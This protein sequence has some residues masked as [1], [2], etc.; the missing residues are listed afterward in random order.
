MKTDQMTGSH[1]MPTATGSDVPGEGE[2][3]VRLILTDQLFP[4][5]PDSHTTN[6]E[7]QTASA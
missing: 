2:C 5:Y 3:G 6:S 7:H 1:P 4:V